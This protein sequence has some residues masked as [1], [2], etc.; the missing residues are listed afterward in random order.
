MTAGNCFVAWKVGWEGKE[1][2][3]EREK[4]KIW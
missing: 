3:V 2:K 1:E 4:M